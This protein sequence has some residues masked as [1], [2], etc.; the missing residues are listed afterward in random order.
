[1]RAV[2]NKGHTTEFCL[3]HRMFAVGAKA[4]MGR[5]GSFR[6]LACCACGPRP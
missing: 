2:I 6:G 3:V 5:G 4:D 1:M